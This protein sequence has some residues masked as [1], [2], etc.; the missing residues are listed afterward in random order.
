[1]TLSSI[2][3]KL[4]THNRKNYLLYLFCNFIS[5]LMITAYSAMMF[6][7][8]VMNILP[9]G[10]DSR[11]Q[12]IA[13]FVLA[14]VGCIVF[15]IYAASLFYRMKSKEIGTMMLLGAPRKALSMQLLK[16]VSA[17]S[18]SSSLA[19]T[20][21]GLPFAWLIW[22]LFRLFIVDSPEMVLSF[23]LRCYIVSVAFATVSIL[24]TFLLALIYLKKTNVIDVVNTQHR[25]EPLR[26]IKKW[27]G[28]VGI[29]LMLFGAIFGYYSGSIYMDVF[30]AYPPA[31]V[32]LAYAPVFIGLYM[33]LLNVVVN[34]F[35]LSHRKK[36]K[37]LISRSMMK[38][39]GRQTVNNMLVV[40]VLIAGGLFA[41]FYAPMLGTS[42]S[43]NYDSMA[44]DYGIHYPQAMKASVPDEE[45]ISAMARDSGLDGIKDYRM[46]ETAI[47]AVSGQREI[48]E[49]N[50]KF[51]YEYFRRNGMEK[52][53]SESSYN[54]LSEA[55]VNVS[56]GKYAAINPPDQ[57]GSYMLPTDA[58]YITNMVTGQELPITFSGYIADSMLGDRGYYILDDED[59]R[60]ITE[61][62]TEKWMEE[63]VFFNADGT[64]GTDDEDS[65]EFSRKFFD[66]FVDVFAHSPESKRYLIYD[67]YDFL[68]EA[69]ADASRH[70]YEEYLSA[71]LGGLSYEKRDSS[72]FR[73]YWMYMPQSRTLDSQEFMKTMAVFLMIF[74]FIALICLAVSMIICHTRSL[75]IA[76]NNRYVFDALRRLGA[77][78]SFLL[79]EATGQ[80]SKVFAVPAVVGASA[81]YLL[82]GLIMYAND[83]QISMNEIM[84]MGVCLG[85]V[86]AVVLVIYLI[87]RLTLRQ[88]CRMLDI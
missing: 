18:L 65:Y 82:Y 88:M 24:A 80:C 40:T 56:R 79:K 4:R 38:F 49:E 75:T 2:F 52:F 37:G 21:L 19:G 12:L 68:S 61:G 10:G 25:N 26:G 15:T 34:G 47:L 1:M 3:A 23:D 6:S 44:F 85:V 14:C 76:I 5:L 83:D 31:W 39:Q 22:Q 69:E 60:L 86:V 54:A 51:H 74:I 66:T 70:T 64:D 32:N 11:K 73:M 84:G 17:I 77:S 58:D 81:M 53:L 87:Y 71:E 50:G 35:G 13:I 42:A 78:P 72:D 46:V 28:P 55:S 27:F 57:N 30:S 33:F 7:P 8:T 20:A 62:L 16:E 59:Y 48:E 36:Y 43:M 45:R 67:N 41:A 9:E 29:A 63:T